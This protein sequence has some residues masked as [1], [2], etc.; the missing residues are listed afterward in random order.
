MHIAHSQGAL[1]TL[2]AARRLSP[3]EL[4]QIE[5]ISFGGGAVL[6]KSVQTP[7]A[8]CVNYY[9]V[10]DP[11]LAIVPS[12]ERAL[13]SGFL[14]VCS[15][16]L[17]SNEPEF[18]FL[19]PRVDH[20]IIDHGLLGPTYAEALDW[21]GRRY[22]RLYVPLPYR[23]ARAFA[24]QTVA[25]LDGMS[26]RT[27]SALIKALQKTLVPF[28][29]SVMQVNAWLKTKCENV[30]NLILLPI[31]LLLKYF[32]ELLKETVK[33]W[34]GEDEYEPVLIARPSSEKPS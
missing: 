26:E 23:M 14:G 34:R 4:S 18:V 24:L 7:F 17:P 15:R 10:N 27:R 25:A 31:I 12:A 11:I 20:P 30:V 5:I 33:S 1:I 13:R 6:R 28:I 19:T 8:R 3:T 29:M 16:G 22:Q 9:S 32:W 2:L 21:E